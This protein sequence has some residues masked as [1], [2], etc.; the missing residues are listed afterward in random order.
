MSEYNPGYLCSPKLIQPRCLDQVRC[1]IGKI[2]N[3]TQTELAVKGVYWGMRTYMHTADIQ[4]EKKDT[5]K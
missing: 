4:R 3:T 1:G 5:T 2:S